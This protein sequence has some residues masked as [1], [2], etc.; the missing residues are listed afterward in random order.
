[1]FSCV[2]NRGLQACKDLVAVFE[3][4]MSVLRASLAEASE[5]WTP[6]VSCGGPR[7]PKCGC[8]LCKLKLAKA[9]CGA[10][11]T[12]CQVRFLDC[13]EPLRITRA[14]HGA[15]ELRGP[16]DRRASFGASFGA[17]SPGRSTV[18]GFP[19]R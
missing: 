12:A 16:R 13:A 18:I 17:R 11:R 5:D 2:V 1:M 6:P 19:T 4:E 8:A 10:T 14:N 9:M 3:P 7:Y 15:D